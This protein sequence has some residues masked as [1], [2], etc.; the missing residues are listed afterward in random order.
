MASNTQGSAAARP[1]PQSI[2]GFLSR[3]HEFVGHNASTHEFVRDL[4]VY[5][6]A[7]E[8]NFVEDRSRL[9]KQMEDLTLD[10][11]GALKSKRE[12]QSRW[13]DLKDRLNFLSQ[14]QDAVKDRNA[15]ILVLIDGNG[16]LFR[17]HF[18]KEGAEGGRMAAEELHEATLK[19]FSYEED[20]EVVI[21][22]VASVANFSHA[23]KQ[24]GYVDKEAKVLDFI[25]G[26]NQFRASFDFVDVGVDKEQVALKI[27]DS[28]RFHLRNYNCKHV[29]LG[30]S[31]EA[32]H[33][34]FLSGLIRDD[35]TKQR[36]TIL[37]GLPTAQEILDTGIVITSFRTIFRT[38]RLREKPYRVRVAVPSLP[39]PAGP[40][41]VPP[42]S[43]ASI[44]T[45]PSEGSPNSPSVPTAPSGA[46]PNLSYASVIQ[47]ASPPPQVAAAIPPKK[48]S[49]PARP[50]APT[51]KPAPK[52][53]PGPRGLDA[54]L[55]ID[56]GVLEK[57]KKRRD[58]QKLCNNHFL[59]GPC[60]K[61]KDCCF[62]H[63]YK[64]SQAEKNAIA[65]LARMNPCTNGQNCELDNCIY[66][67]HCPTV[68]NGVCMHPNCRFRTEEHPPGTRF[69]FPRNYSHTSDQ[70]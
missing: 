43:A 30:I 18:I 45:V 23:F 22:V 50:A 44:S 48:A 5:A 24:G 52:W 35:R 40:S 53:N 70:D 46:R 62:E 34:P 27:R 9:R 42:P 20:V 33:A 12:L 54:P 26:F 64:P 56:Q 61:G 36:V 1:Q 11:K 49:A 10:L 7:A 15:Y 8:G 25:A 57:L 68:V 19:K 13:Y 21:K 51:K 60:T 39:I 65:Y 31:H 17:E 58:N 37:E 14:G 6:E 16:L 4:L 69:K 29:L 38:D 59:R 63:N 3:Y 47:K 41:K 66:G 2:M 32:S 67:H 55:V 28:T